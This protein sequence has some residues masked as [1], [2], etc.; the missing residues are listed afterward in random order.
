MARPSG[1]GDKRSSWL[2]FQRRLGVARRLIRGEATQDEI[3]AAVQEML[4]KDV[5]PPDDRSAL[6][7]DLTSLR[8]DFG[9]TITFSKGKYRIVTLGK[10]ALLDLPDEELEAI[11]LLNRM[12]AE[13]NL[14]NT[15]DM[16]K[17]LDRLVKL[18]PKERQEQLALIH[19]QPQ[20]QAPSLVYVLPS[21][22]QAVLS[23]ALYRQQVSFLYESP[24]Y[25][26][27]EPLYHRVA[28][29]NLVYRDG[30]IYLDGYCLA[31]D[32]RKLA[33]QYHPYRLSRIVHG[34]LRV[35]PET[36][37]PVQPERPIYTLR[38]EL[39]PNVACQKDI[40]VWFDQSHVTFR[41]DGSALVE[42]QTDNLWQ[43]RQVLLRYREHCRVLEPPE[44]IEMMHETVD[45][46]H[47]LYQE[48]NL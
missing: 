18:L 15:D 23:R 7:H 37:P 4:G 22:I 34:S 6:R 45:K 29:Y 16:E 2:T 46:M 24:H 27:Q 42:G 21:D 26:Q 30:H 38:Y 10:F 43:A 9:C 48:N 33:K 41:E 32:N 19:K 1:G 13:M 11:S 17:V 47:T 8:S 3:I 20:I 12:I 25:P 44:L 31:C 14:P 36:I 35:L 40:S 28:P 5:Y 39:A